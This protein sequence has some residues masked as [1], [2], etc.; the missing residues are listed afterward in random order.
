MVSLR[1]PISLHVLQVRRCDLLRDRHQQHRSATN[2]GQQAGDGDLLRGIYLRCCILSMAIL[3]TYLSFVTFL[4]PVP[5]HLPP[6]MS[7]RCSVCLSL[8]CVCLC[9][10]IKLCVSVLLLFIPC[11]VYPSVSVCLCMCITL[12][13][14]MCVS[15][16]RL[17]CVS[18]SPCCCSDSSYSHSHTLTITC[19]CCYDEIKGTQDPDLFSCSFSLIIPPGLL[20]SSP[21][22][23]SL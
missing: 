19:T 3:C 23:Q 16:S 15:F 9:M 4:S 20:F 12:Y 2:H 8:L 17:L 10:F 21:S 13:V 18:P 22:H 1:L 14:S 11:S 6:S 5:L 7:I